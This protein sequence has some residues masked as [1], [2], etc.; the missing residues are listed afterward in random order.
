MT[1][2][3]WVTSRYCILCTHFRILNQMMDALSFVLDQ[4]NI[5]EEWCEYSVSKWET[6]V[7]LEFLLWSTGNPWTQTT[8]WWFSF[9]RDFTGEGWLRLVALPID[10][11]SFIP[12]SVSHNLPE[13]LLAPHLLPTCSTNLQPRTMLFRFIESFSTYDTTAFSTNF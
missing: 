10:G 2:L 5:A 11:T 13:C 12:S 8:M 1:F 6:N 3:T 4:R 7:Y 9:S